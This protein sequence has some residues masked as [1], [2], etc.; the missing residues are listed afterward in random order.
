V[1]WSK[2]VPVQ[3]VVVWQVPQLV[4]N[5]AAACGGVDV[6]PNS[7][8]WHDT[9]AVGRSR[10]TPSPWQLAHVAARC[11]PVSAKSVALWSKGAPVQAV[12]V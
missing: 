3:A 2:G 8:W 10:Y 6:R 5:P 4:E 1:L 12:V 9:Q 11:A 7:C